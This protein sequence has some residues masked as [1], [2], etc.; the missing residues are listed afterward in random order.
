MAR[1]LVVRWAPARR[2][3]VAVVTLAVGSC[4]SEVTAPTPRS[5]PIGLTCPAAVELTSTSQSATG[6][7]SPPLVSGGDPP[8]AVTCAPASGSTFPLGPTTVSCAAI[9]AVN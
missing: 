6:A 9:D 2:L 8:V 7:Y 5:A 4:S 3:P 1:K